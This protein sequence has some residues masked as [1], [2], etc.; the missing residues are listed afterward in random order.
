MPFT[1]IT[2]SPTRSPPAFLVLVLVLVLDYPLP[3]KAH[4]LIVFQKPKPKPK[5]KQKQN[6]KLYVKGEGVAVKG[7]GRGL[8]TKINQK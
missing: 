7:V 4:W 3:T 2:A 1:F 8:L 5:Q 6:P